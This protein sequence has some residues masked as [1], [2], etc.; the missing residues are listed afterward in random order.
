MIKDY[1]ARLAFDMLSAHGGEGGALARGADRQVLQQIKHA[2]EDSAKPNRFRG[3]EDYTD[4]AF[5]EI[6]RIERRLSG[7]EYGTTSGRGG[8][9]G[10][11]RGRGRGA[12]RFGRECTRTD[13]HF[14]HPDGKGGGSGRS[15]PDGRSGGSGRSGGARGGRRS[16]GR[17]AQ[18]PNAAPRHGEAKK[19]AKKEEEGEEPKEERTPS[20][21]LPKGT[22]VQVQGLQSAEGALLNG[23]RGGVLSYN[24][25]KDR[26]IVQL[27][28]EATPKSLKP[29]RPLPLV[30]RC[31]C[32]DCLVAHFRSFV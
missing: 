7:R 8:G 11:G 32:C 22:R 10:G 28:T 30:C 16:G 3:A 31:L 19:A 18:T 24:V 4:D 5:A 9:R 15:G 21:R 25:E 2:N 13:C 20:N 23:T 17:A 1:V 29:V 12:C 14:E 27:T 6:Q 26:Y